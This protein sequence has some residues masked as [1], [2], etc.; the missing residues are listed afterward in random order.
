[1]NIGDCVEQLIYP[2]FDHYRHTLEAMGRGKAR[3]R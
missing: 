1:M 3:R 2:L